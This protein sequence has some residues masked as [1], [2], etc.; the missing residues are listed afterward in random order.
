MKQRND[1]YIII[2]V[3]NL[4]QEAIVVSTSGA[5]L[6]LLDKGLTCDRRMEILNYVMTEFA[7]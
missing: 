6:L 2:D 7:A 3:E 1:G 5:P 4:G